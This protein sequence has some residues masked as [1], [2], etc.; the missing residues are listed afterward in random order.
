[1]I[2]GCGEAAEAAVLHVILSVVVSPRLKYLPL[3]QVSAWYHDNY[4]IS[5]L[6]RYQTKPKQQKINLKMTYLRFPLLRAQDCKNYGM[7]STKV[8]IEN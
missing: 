4:I 6:H 1:M 8:K 7:L 5:L 2:S 3:A